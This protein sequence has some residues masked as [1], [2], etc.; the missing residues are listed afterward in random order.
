MS[1]RDTKRVLLDAAAEEFARLGLSG[2]R[3]QAIVARAGI[4]ERMVY[5][6]FGSKVGLYRAVLADQFRAPT[7]PAQPGGGDAKERFIATLRELVRALIKRP[8][9]IALSLHEAMV[10][11]QNVPK[12]SLK[13]I[14]EA[15]RSTFEAAKKAGAIR[16]DCKFE[17][18]YLA[19]VGAMVSGHL[20][21]GRFVD[22]RTD[23]ARRALIADIFEL[24]L[25]GAMA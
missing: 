6:H 16:K 15:V 9:L 2:A 10:G 4:N 7:I 18:V 11:W 22:L 12:A 5:H 19:A 3:M 25:R 23:K 24:V 13:D 1:D 14:P 17:V 20:L 8:L 21:S